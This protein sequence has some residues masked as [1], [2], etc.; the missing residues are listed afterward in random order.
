[1]AIRHV[2]VIAAAFFGTIPLAPVAQADPARIMF[3]FGPSG[4]TRPQEGGGYTTD[5][6]CHAIAVPSAPGQSDPA[7]TGVMVPV[8]TQLTCSVNGISKS[9]VSPGGYTFTRTVMVTE[10]PVRICGVAK[11]AFLMTDAQGASTTSDI[12]VVT[13]EECTILPT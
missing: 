8:A 11:A 10:P 2:V 1:M 7:M 6:M 3:R 13:A 12:V 9:S 5:V 4:N